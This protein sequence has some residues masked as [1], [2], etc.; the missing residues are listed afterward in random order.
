MHLP[1]NSILSEKRVAMEVSFRS[2]VPEIFKLPPQ[3]PKDIYVWRDNNAAEVAME[4][5]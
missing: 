4:V 5:I 3:P 2:V 1:Q